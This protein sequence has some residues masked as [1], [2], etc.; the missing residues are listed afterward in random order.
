MGQTLLDADGIRRTLADMAKRIEADVPAGVP[1]AFVG[2]R[3]RGDVLAARLIEQLCGDGFTDVAS[4]ALDITLYRDD[5][6]HKGPKAVLQKTEIDFDVD[7]RYLILVDDVLHTGRSVRA[8]LDAIVD[9]GR[10]LAIRLAV[11]VARPGRELPIQADFVGIEV[12]DVEKTVKVLI[13]E[14]DGRD[15]VEVE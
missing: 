3:S 1:I 2:I 6:A 12:R 9:L 14:H 8:A 4:G 10:P 7:G 13:R 15:A 5:L 11:L